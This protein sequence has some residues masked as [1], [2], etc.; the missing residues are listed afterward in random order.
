MKKR[1]H[2]FVSAIIWKEAGQNGEGTGFLISRNLVLTVAH[3][4]YNGEIRLKN[5]SIKIY[6]GAFG[7][8]KDAC[9]I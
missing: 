4:F 6:P 1:L 8:L 9:I 7:E 2:K 3:N 5:D